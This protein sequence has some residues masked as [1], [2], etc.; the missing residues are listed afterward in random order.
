MTWQ[1]IVLKGVSSNKTDIRTNLNI[2]ALNI[3]KH[4]NKN[5]SIHIFGLKSVG[6]KSNYIFCVLK[7][8]EQFHS[9]PL[10]SNA[11]PQLMSR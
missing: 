4:V 6:M 5:K 9:R 2:S 1:W 7:Q 3:I 8:Q 11:Q 10:H